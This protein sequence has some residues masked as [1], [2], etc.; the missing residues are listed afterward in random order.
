LGSKNETGAVPDS[1]HDGMI[2]VTIEEFGIPSLGESQNPE[3]LF[4]KSKVLMYTFPSQLGRAITGKPES[5]IANFICRSGQPLEIRPSTAIG[6]DVM[7]RQLSMSCLE[8]RYVVSRSKINC[9]FCSRA[10]DHKPVLRSVDSARQS[11][12]SAKF[13]SLAQLTRTWHHVGMA[14]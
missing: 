9:D 7:K 13:I 12:V 8:R 3:R 10:W 2:D 11:L 14:G 4:S 6:W 1:R 5:I